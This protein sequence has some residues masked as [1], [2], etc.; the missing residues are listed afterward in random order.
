L[1]SGISCAPDENFS[2]TSDEEEA[3]AS[4][5][6]RMNV[7]VRVQTPMGVVEREVSPEEFRTII[8]DECLLIRDSGIPAAPHLGCLGED[9]SEE[10][11]QTCQM[12]T[13]ASN[14]L[15]C[16]SHRARELAEILEPTDLLPTE[17][18]H[19]PA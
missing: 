3:W 16:M 15:L 13:C 11:P 8:R 19:D 7:T 1:L 17:A 18:R 12:A 9:Y 10:S 5:R 6:A 2:L 4:R 14:L